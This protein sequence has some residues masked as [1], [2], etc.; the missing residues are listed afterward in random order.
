MGPLKYHSE[1]G[2]PGSN[3]NEGVLYTLQIPKTTA[4]PSDAVSCHYSGAGRSVRVF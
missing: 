1:S 2:G 3:E 4:S